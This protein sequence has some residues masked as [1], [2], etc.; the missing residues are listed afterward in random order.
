MKLDTMMR[1]ATDDVVVDVQT[2]TQEARANGSR[3]RRRRHLLSASGVLAAGACVFGASVAADV[4]TSGSGP[5]PAPSATS[6]PAR[7]AQQAPV[8]TTAPLDGRATAA[9]LEATV[10]AVGDGELSKFAG[11]GGPDRP[12]HGHDTYAEFVMTPADGLGAGVVGVNVQDL[13]ILR[14]QPRTCLSF[15]VDCTADEL[16]GGAVLRSYRDPSDT[17]SDVR[18]VA[19]LLAPSRGIRVVVSSTNGFDLGANRW[20]ITRDAPVLGAAQLRDIV[21]DERWGFEVPAEL[22]E[23]G[24]ALS[25]YDD[26]DTHQAVESPSPS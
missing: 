5:D 23:R 21:L 22:A 2:L 9:L 24:A 20:D 15:M 11:Q 14:G 26:L 17:G 1:E 8:A 10:L 19:E 13:S 6:S 7:V 4:A 16:P 18:M 12:D 3:M 25:P